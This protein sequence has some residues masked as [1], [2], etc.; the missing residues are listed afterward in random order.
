MKQARSLI[1]SRFKELLSAAAFVG[2]LSSEKGEK[3]RKYDRKRS[4]EESIQKYKLSHS[5]VTNMSSERDG[6]G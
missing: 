3:K 6:L 4:P 1:Y 5:G 2:F